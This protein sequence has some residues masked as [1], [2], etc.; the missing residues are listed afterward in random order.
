MMLQLLYH[1]A[2]LHVTEYVLSAIHA[3]MKIQIPQFWNTLVDYK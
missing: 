1:S 3:L 2:Y